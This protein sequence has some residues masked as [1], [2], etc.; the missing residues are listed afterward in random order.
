MINYYSFSFSFSAYLNYHT[1][2]FS[3]HSILPISKDAV[4]LNVI[5]HSINQD[6]KERSLLQHIIENRIDYCKY[7][8]S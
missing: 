2:F 6:V 8:K 3:L 1:F 7:E 5:S 4:R